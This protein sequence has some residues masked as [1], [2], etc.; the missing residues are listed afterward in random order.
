M[1]TLDWNLDVWD[2][3]Y[4]WAH[5]GD[6]WSAPWGGSEA[7]W[8]SCILPRVARFLPAS[9]ILEIAP[10]F[11]RWTE[12]LIPRCNTYLGVD[13]AESCVTACTER[14]SSHEGVRFEV[15]DG[16]SLP[17]V[18]SG[19]VDFV[20]SFDSL[21]HVEADVIGA[22]LNEFRRI[23]GEDGV[24]FIHHSNIGA[25]RTAS[26][27]LDGVTLIGKACGKAVLRNSWG[28]AALTRAGEANWHQARG[29][30][31]TADRFVELSRDAGLACVGQE[32]INWASPLLIDCISIVTQPGSTWERPNVRVTNRSFRA[33][34]RS[35]AM[36]SKVFLSMEAKR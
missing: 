24:A 4:D 6:E 15:N 9:S 5:G 7:Q 12:Q 27:L 34:A 25:Y 23:L 14:F 17:M 3:N 18:P 8:R 13:L 33:A 21:V 28:K 19:S 16:R 10:G 30:S 29:R 22:Y 11:G 31:M 36:S 1:P 2:R 26:G 35:S 20:F 32:I